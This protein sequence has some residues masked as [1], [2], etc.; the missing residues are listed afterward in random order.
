MTSLTSKI[1]V[2]G[3]TFTHPDCITDTIY[4]SLCAERGGEK[5]ALI[6]F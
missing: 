4:P 6:D 1:E 5:F 2:I 3:F